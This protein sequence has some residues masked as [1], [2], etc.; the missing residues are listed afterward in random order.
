MERLGNVVIP[1]REEILKK[2]GR[3]GYVPDLTYLKEAPGTS[4]ASKLLRSA[5][6]ESESP[7]TATKIE[8]APSQERLRELAAQRRKERLSRSLDP[9]STRINDN[10]AKLQAAASLSREVIFKA[11]V[12]VLPPKE[13]QRVAKSSD[14]LRKERESRNPKAKSPKPQ[15]KNQAKAQTKPASERKPVSKQQEVLQPEEEGETVALDYDGFEEGTSCLPNLPGPQ[16]VS[17]TLHDIFQTNPAQP[18]PV[19]ATAAGKYPVPQ[20]LVSSFVKR[21]YVDYVPLTN[22]D[23]AQTPKQLG[24]VKEAQVILSHNPHYPISH[25]KHTLNIIENAVSTQG[26]VRAAAAA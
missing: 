26:R 4:L 14:R 16:A 10:A 5:T 17:R 3:G 12:S 19:L 15:H 25:R 8:P 24:P 21:N 9:L 6:G 7:P 13:Y 23:F 1:S 11:G 18:K 22:Q 2:S 20:G